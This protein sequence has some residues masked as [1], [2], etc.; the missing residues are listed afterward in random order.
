MLGFD[1]K[2][3]RA[4]WTVMVVLLAAYVT[5][6]LRFTLFIFVLALLLAHLLSPLVDLID[7]LL[8][9]SRTR[10]RTPALAMAYVI[11][12]GLVVLLAIQ[13]GSVAVKQAQSLAS[14]FPGM[15]QSAVASWQNSSTGNATLDSMKQEAI[16]GVVNKVGG[17]AS[18]LPSMSV[19]IVSVASNVIFVVIIPILSFFFLKD[20]AALRTHIVEMLDEGPNRRVLED[21]LDAM[22]L[23]LA[24][25]MRSLVMLSAAAFTAYGIFFTIL[26]IPYGVL[27]AALGG[28]LE[29]I[30]MLGPFV[31]GAAI[32]LVAGVTTGHV[33][34]VIIFL[35][36]YRIV[37]DYII[38]PHIMEQGVEIHPLM[39][40]FGVFAGAEIAGVA[41]TFLSV[42]IL[43]LVR[44]VY[45]RLYRAKVAARIAVPGPAV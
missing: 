7:R 31:A 27:L 9:A 11:F 14:K 15:I 2:A 39:V 41:G 1:S 26:G 40:L 28:L 16:G 34:G 20:A 25:Y 3:A 45:L 33:I 8:P 24:G 30:P 13:F 19:E 37:Q 32:V 6:L 36:A 5:Y 4:T 18:A 38:A 21:V 17:I 29:F 10:T 12:V 23:V 22:H 42:P 44:I 43:A 35:V